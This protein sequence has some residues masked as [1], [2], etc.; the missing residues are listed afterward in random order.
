MTLKPLKKARSQKQPAARTLP[1]RR[2]PTLIGHALVHTLMLI[3]PSPSAPS[4]RISAVTL[5]KLTS[6]KVLTPPNQSLFLTWL[7]VKLA[8][9]RLSPSATLQVSRRHHL[10]AWMIL[11]PK[12]L[13]LSIRSLSYTALRRMEALRL[14]SREKRNSLVMTSHQETTPIV[15]WE[16]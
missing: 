2:L 1:A 14:L 16:R 7:R 10:R 5:V 6:R 4:R 11:T 12:S 8:P 15:T 3:M 13:S 9:S